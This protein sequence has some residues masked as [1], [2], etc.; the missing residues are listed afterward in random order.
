MGIPTSGSVTWNNNTFVTYHYY[1]LFVQDAFR[2]RPN[3]TVNVGLRWDVN[4]SPSERHNRMNGDF[5]LTCTNPYTQQVNFTNA[6][7]LQSPLLGG[8]TFTSVN[9][10]PSAPFNVQWSDWQPRFGVSWL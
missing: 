1:G 5:C 4:K 2:L 8:W 7:L 6:P 9:G 10:V 3:L